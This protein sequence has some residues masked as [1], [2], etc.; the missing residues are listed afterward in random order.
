MLLFSPND[1]S[2]DL[3]IAVYESSGHGEA[4]S[5]MFS[6]VPVVIESGEAERI[7]VELVAQARDE[8]AVAPGTDVSLKLRRC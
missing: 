1:A 5:P 4:G 6:P 8:T 3:P 7:A 2:G